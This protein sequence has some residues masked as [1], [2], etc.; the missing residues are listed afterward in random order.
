MLP[1]DGDIIGSRIAEVIVSV[2]LLREQI[3]TL[4]LVLLMLTVVVMACCLMMVTLL[5]VELL[6]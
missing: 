5:V 3:D 2:W 6:K 4:G 1:N